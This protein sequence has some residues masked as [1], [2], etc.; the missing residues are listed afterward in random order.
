MANDSPEQK[1]QRK[2]RYQLIAKQ[3]PYAQKAGMMIIAGSDCA[4][5]NTFVYPAASLFRRTR[6]ISKKRYEAFRN[7]PICH[8]ERSKIYGQ[9]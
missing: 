1:Q 4:A 3:L 9:I 2:D 5:L 6:V 7:S 8:H